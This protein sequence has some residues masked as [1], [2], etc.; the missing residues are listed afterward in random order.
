[1]GYL[2]EEHFLVQNG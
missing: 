2:E 1:M